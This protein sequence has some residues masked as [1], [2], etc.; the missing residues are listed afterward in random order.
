[1]ALLRGVLFSVSIFVLIVL[2]WESFHSQA[3]M[4]CHWNMMIVYDL[5]AP[6]NTI[7]TQKMSTV[8]WLDY[9]YM[10]ELQLWL[11]HKK[12]SRPIEYQLYFPWSESTYAK[13]TKDI[14]SWALTDWGIW[15]EAYNFSSPFSG[16][17]TICFLCEMFSN[18]LRWVIADVER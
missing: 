9:S 8:H 7:L 15:T 11:I 16:L 2:V 1:M 10:L 3:N 4:S 13:T 18:T 12:Q 14:W 6:F 5:N 17:H